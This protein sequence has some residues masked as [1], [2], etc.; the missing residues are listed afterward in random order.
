MDTGQK[1]EL[2]GRAAQYDLCGCACGTDASRKQDDLGR[3]IYPAVLPDGK[4][5]S[6]LKV[7]LTNVCEKD[8]FYCANRAS[9]DTRRISFSP[10]E[11]ARAFDEMRRKGLVEGLFLSSGVCANALHTMDR[12]I[13][14]VELVRNR[15]HFPGYVHLKLLPGVTFAQVERAIQ[16]AH[17]V[18]VNLEAPNVQ[19]LARIAP[20]KDFTS[21]LLEPMRWVQQIRGNSAGHLIPAGQT[22]QFVVGAADESD[23]E[24]LSTTEWLYR[25]LGLARAYFSAFQPVH[26]TPLEGHPPAP[27]LREHRLYQSDFLF[28]RYGFTLAELVFDERGNL[29]GEA[30]PKMAWALAH[31][32]LFPVEVNRAGRQELLRVPG[33]GPRSATR[34]VILRRQGAF[35]DL[36]E[37][38]KI[39][40]MTDRAAPF[41]L[42][43][44]KC[45]PYQLSLWP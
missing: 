12:M 42:L 11:L 17:R 29:P 20:R 26:D 7:L 36:H 1:M 45:P 43:D 38:R 41:I 9:R 23:Y 34:I 16:L 13:A 8:C 15:Y 22:T 35:R 25:N 31:P 3:W 14:T 40:V 2:L 33:I 24:I 39:G 4:R 44:G 28:R 32:E 21:D 10:D 30:D 6:I 37:L 27:P 5:V 19:S 18:S